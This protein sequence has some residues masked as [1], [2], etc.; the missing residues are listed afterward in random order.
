MAEAVPESV[1]ALSPTSLAMLAASAVLVATSA[2][3]PALATGMTKRRFERDPAGDVAEEH[4]DRFE[5]PKLMD[6][7]SLMFLPYT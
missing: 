7:G 3:V 5:G 4:A 1:R 2:A 6:L